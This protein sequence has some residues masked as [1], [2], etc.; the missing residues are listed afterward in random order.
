MKQSID[1][2]YLEKER[3]IKEKV[4]RYMTYGLGLSLVVECVNEYKVQKV[5]IYIYI[6]RNLGLYS[7]GRWQHG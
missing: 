5:Y 2:E 1:E 7:A 4:L 6:Y 3:K